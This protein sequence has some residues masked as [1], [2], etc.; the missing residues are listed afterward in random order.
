M[1]RLLCI[2]LCCLALLTFGPAQV[3]LSNDTEPFQELKTNLMLQ[4]LN[5]LDE[6]DHRI[7]NL[8][9]R[10]QS[11]NHATAE[12]IAEKLQGISD[13]LENIN[14]TLRQN[15]GTY[16]ASC[17]EA[18]AFLSDVYTIKPPASSVAP[19]RVYCEQS[20]RKGG[21]IVLL[22]RFDGSVNFTRDWMDYRDGFGT[23][24]GEYWLGLEKIHRITAADYFQLLVHLKDHDGTVKTALYD[25]FEVANESTGYR[26]HLGS[27]IDGNANDS[28]RISN[29][30]KFSTPD[31]DNDEHPGSC[32]AFY[33]SG[34]WYRNCMNA[35]L[36]GLYRQ[37]DPNNATMNWF[38]FRNDLQGLKEA[39]MMIRAVAS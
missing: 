29:A 18:P 34:W 9:R 33:A 32:A 3:A 39:T 2:V 11:S 10:I 22:R 7:S 17:Q 23:V 30:M 13:K 6:I 24:E 5:R 4:V 31:R 1:E 27:Y 8:E 20:Y 14:K 38:G 28:L 16:Y 25:E 19:F 36:N 35:N 12:V 26:L 15:V 21:W 37:T